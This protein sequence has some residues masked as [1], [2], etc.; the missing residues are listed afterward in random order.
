MN[1]RRVG[2]VH[3]P[4]GV[5]TLHHLQHLKAVSVTRTKK[6]KTKT[7][8]KKR[9]RWQH[10]SDTQSLTVTQR[11]TQKHASTPTRSR[12]TRCLSSDCTSG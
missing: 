11:A 8:F 10:S 2:W 4:G 6:L 5:G 7:L 3:A 9:T 1:D 12:A